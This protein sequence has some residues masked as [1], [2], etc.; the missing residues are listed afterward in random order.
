MLS[1]ALK[2]ILMLMVIMPPGTYRT[3]QALGRRLSSQERPIA[4][5]VR[6]EGICPPYGRVD[7]LPAPTRARTWCQTTFTL[8]KSWN[9]DS[10][11]VVNSTG[12][13]HAVGLS[14]AAIRALSP[15]AMM[16][17]ATRS[18]RAAILALHELLI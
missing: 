9:A 17:E 1:V 7:S 2:T 4:K 16:P 15:Q 13:W 18:P 12:L 6:R 8:Q 10:L 14:D 3:L 5:D 11:D